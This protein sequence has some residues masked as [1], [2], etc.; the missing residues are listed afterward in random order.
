MNKHTF[1]Q[2]IP[3]WLAE[4]H[5]LLHPYLPRLL[6][7]QLITVVAQVV[8]KGKAN[9]A[10]RCHFVHQL[11]TEPYLGVNGWVKRQVQQTHPSSIGRKGSL[12][13]ILAQLEKLAYFHQNPNKIAA[14]FCTPILIDVQ[15]ISQRGHPSLANNVAYWLAQGE[16]QP[17]AVR[18]AAY[19]ASV[20]SPV[21]SN[22]R[23]PEQR[24]LY[25]QGCQLLMVLKAALIPRKRWGKVAKRKRGPVHQRRVVAH[26]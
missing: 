25:W 10:L 26:A 3:A 19:W 12:E 9:D 6:Q 22:H 5:D 23:R 13:P 11:L 14:G 2:D 1:R 21:D 24:H 20:Y 7:Q 8:S 18:E 16:G 17:L 4:L 15:D